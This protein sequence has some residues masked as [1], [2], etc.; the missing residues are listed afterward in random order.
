MMPN[1]KYTCSNCGETTYQVFK[2]IDRPKSIICPACENEAQY[3]IDAPAVMEKALPDTAGRGKHYSEIKE[4]AR[5]KKIE[6]DLPVDKRTDVK[7]E[8]RKITGE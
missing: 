8:L 7:K 6:A 3:S 4:Y 1:Y 2:Y 5:L